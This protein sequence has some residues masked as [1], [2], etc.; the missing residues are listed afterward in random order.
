MF[1]DVLSICYLLLIHCPCLH[2]KLQNIYLHERISKSHKFSMFYDVLSNCC[3]SLLI[4]ADFRSGQCQC[5]CKS[6]QI[7]LM[8]FSYLQSLPEY[9][10]RSTLNSLRSLNQRIERI[11]MIIVSFIFVQE[12]T[13]LLFILMDLKF[14]SLFNLL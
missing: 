4:H 1:Y 14:L 8:S 5:A 7:L 11:A 2:Q 9:W 3:L 10:R 12:I 6:L 13:Y